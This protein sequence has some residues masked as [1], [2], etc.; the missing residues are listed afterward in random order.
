[1]D[2][3]K[4]LGTSMMNAHTFSA[5]PTPADAVTPSVLTIA[6]IIRKEMLTRKSWMA[7]GVPRPS[8]FPISIWF[9]LTDC[10]SKANGS[11][12]LEIIQSDST[13]ESACA[14]TVAAAAPAAPI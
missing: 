5:T 7:I 4:E 2:C 14:A 6:R 10:L 13:T 11:C 8:T 12:F 1:M 3:M 9:H